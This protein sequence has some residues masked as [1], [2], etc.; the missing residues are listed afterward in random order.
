MASRWPGKDRT[1]LILFRL[2]VVLAINGVVIYGVGWAEWNGATALAVYWVETLTGGLLI[3]VRIWLHRRWTRKRG[4][5]R[6]QLGVTVSGA[7]DNPTT[8]NSFFAEYLTL[9]IVFSLGH[10]VFL[11]AFL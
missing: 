5:Y 9:I 3:A 10:A 2:L 4:H 11:G 6:S 1:L 7:G 8:I